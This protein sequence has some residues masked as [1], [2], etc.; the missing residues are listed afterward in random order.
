M[1]KLLEITK[2]LNVFNLTKYFIL[3]IIILLSFTQVLNAQRVRE[4]EMPEPKTRILFVFDASQSMFGRWQS[5][6]RINIAR[7]LLSNL[8][9]SLRGVENL[10]LAIRIYGHQKNFPPQ[11][12]DDTNLEV[13]FGPNNTERIKSKL[14]HVVPRGTTPIALSLEAA[15]NDFPPCSDCRNIIILI[16][17]GIEECG[18]DPCAVSRALQRSGIILRPFVIGIGRD[19]SA[20]F[21]CVG[22]YYDA[23]SE[24]MFMDALRVVISQALNNTTAQVNLLDIYG[25]PSE[26]NVNMS[27]YDNFSGILK[28]NYVHT[29]NNRGVPDTIIIDHLATYNIVVHT[30]PP[31]RKDSVRL[32]AG[33]HTVIGIDA[34]QGYLIL[35]AAGRPLYRDLQAIIRKN[36]QMETL[37]TQL[38]GQ[39][40]KYI[41]G[42]YDIE[43]LCLPRLIINDVEI[44]QSTTTTVEIPQPGIAVIQKPAAGFGSLYLEERNELKL[45]YNLQESNLQES[46]ILQPG[47]YKVIFR[48]KFA[49]RA[50]NTIERSFI[51]ES[52]KTQNV[53]LFL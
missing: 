16:T 12:C 47:K 23:S 48:A 17:D 4:Q 43:V 7:R 32:V 21:E 8:L 33:S 25:N 38:F 40:E 51:I 41:V 49:T 35:K 30:I 46:I 13:P 1:K 14:N 44:S 39:T 5:D 2:L 37:N 18:G 36:D 34:P 11:D 53:R 9:D 6:M 50:L 20:D 29:M 24:Q 10:E 42:K 27:F 28:Y 45:I 31:V 19:F 15:A 26:S 22:D 52:G 3:S